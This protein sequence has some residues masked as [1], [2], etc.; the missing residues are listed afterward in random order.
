MA[1]FLAALGM[2]GPA[3]GMTVPWPCSLMIS[4][5]AESILSEAEGLRMMANLRLAWQKG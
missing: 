2:T 1:R 3:L 4:F 5:F